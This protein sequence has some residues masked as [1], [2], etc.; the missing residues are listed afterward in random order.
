MQSGTGND[1]V[2][3]DLSTL[4]GTSSTGN[5]GWQDSSESRVIYPLRLSISKV[6]GTKIVE[7]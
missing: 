3:V 1:W 7:P 2:Q 6:D 5:F 4:D